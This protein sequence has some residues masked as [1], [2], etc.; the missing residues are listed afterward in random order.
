MGELLLG[1]LYRMLVVCDAVA[2]V[3]WEA[4][5]LLVSQNSGLEASN[6]CDLAD[7]AKS[8]GAC[9]WSDCVGLLCFLRWAV[10]GRLG[11]QVHGILC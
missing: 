9:D 5:G 4:V 8:G 6:S 1:I 3:A 10:L 7:S 11:S 2:A